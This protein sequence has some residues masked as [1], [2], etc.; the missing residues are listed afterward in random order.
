MSNPIIGIYD[1]L[2][3]TWEHRELTDDEVL[4]QVQQFIFNS[5]EVIVADP[6]PLLSMPIDFV[7]SNAENSSDETA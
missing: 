3:D 7:L 2:T 1:A 6:V 5:E 4:E